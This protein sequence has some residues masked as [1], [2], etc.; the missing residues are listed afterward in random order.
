MRA[1]IGDKHVFLRTPFFGRGAPGPQGP[2][3]EGLILLTHPSH[4]GPSPAPYIY[5]YPSRRQVT[6]AHH[7]RPPRSQLSSYT[8]ISAPL[9]I[10]AASK[11]NGLIIGEMSV[12][13]GQLD[14][15]MET[16]ST[17]AHGFPFTKIQPGLIS[18]TVGLDRATNKLFISELWEKKEVSS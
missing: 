13:E 12:K 18:A 8:C 10:M 3:G 5:S 17:H 4:L 15:F 6:I 7:H 1:F 16:W 11:G 9:C 14:A 2:K